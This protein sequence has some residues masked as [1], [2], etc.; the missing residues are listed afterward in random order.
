M[1]DIGPVGLRLI[2][3]LTQYV[4]LRKLNIIISTGGKKCGHSTPMGIFTT[5]GR[6]MTLYFESDNSVQGRGFDMIITSFRDSRCSCG[7]WYF[8]RN[9]IER[10]Q[11]YRHALHIRG[12]SRVFGNRGT[13]TIFSGEQGNKGIKIRGTQAILGNRDIENEDFIMGEQGNKAIFS[14][15][16]REQVLPP[17]RASVH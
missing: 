14:R 6:Y 15:G 5:T 12:L 17:G 1:T 2:L 9:G 7:C 8:L 13:R 11:I 4:I 10:N 16:T 3:L